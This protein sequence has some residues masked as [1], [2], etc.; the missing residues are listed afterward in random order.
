ML[1]TCN[2][3]NGNHNDSTF[4]NKKIHNICLAQ[5]VLSTDT[6]QSLFSYRQN[7]TSSIAISPC[8]KAPPQFIFSFLK[9]APS[10]VRTQE[11]APVLRRNADPR[12]S[13]RGFGTKPGVPDS[14]WGA[15]GKVEGYTDLTILIE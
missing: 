7:P 9:P 11:H 1:S 12:R 3:N 13:S 5:M 10:G 14:H 8:E 6:C 15:Q 4:L 2:I